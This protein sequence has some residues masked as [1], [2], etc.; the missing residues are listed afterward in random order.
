M[1]IDLAGFDIKI[2]DDINTWEEVNLLY[3]S[4]LKQIQTKIEIL[5][6]EFQEVHRYNP[7]EHVKARV[8][9]PESIVKK[10]KRNGYESTIENMVRYVNDIAGIRII[11]SFTSDIYRIAEMISNQKDIQVL[12]VKDY[13]MNPKQSGYRSYHMIVSL[14]VYLSDRIVNVKVEI[15]IRTVAMDFWASLEHKIQYKFE[16]KAPQHINAELHECAAMVAN[17]DEK[18]LQLNDEILAV[19]AEK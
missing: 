4:A 18:M 5:N 13:I 17:L 7:I 12:T 10:L 1:E 16:G 11:C 15:Q 6:E 19:E 9:V 8:K 14:P 2:S 3:N